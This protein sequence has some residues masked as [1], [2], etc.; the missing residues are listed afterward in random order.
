MLTPLFDRSNPPMTLRS[1]LALS[2]CLL[3]L[4]ACETGAPEAEPIAEMED[5]AP[6]IAMAT[7][8]PTEGHQARGT[9]TFTPVDGGVRVNA[10]VTGLA[11]GPH[12]IHVHET[13]DCSAPDASSAGGHFAPEGSPH[14]APDD[15]AS[16]RHTG[17]LGNLEANPEGNAT[18]ERLDSI[19]SLEGPNSIV[20]KAVIVHGGADDLTSQ[21]SGDA[22]PRVACGV[23][24]MQDVTMGA[25]AD[26]L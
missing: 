5:T 4:A 8:E 2:C 24:R 6:A 13:G 1:T 23:I 18:Y 12:G 7:L 3:L 26:T 11:E 15:P 16:E 9:V 25:A 20:G 21:P 22:G 14:G 10:D 17:D 19:L